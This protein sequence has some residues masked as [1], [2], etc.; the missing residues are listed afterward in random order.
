V[1]LH[2]LGAADFQA[3]ARDKRVERHILGF[4]GRDP[5]TLLGEDTT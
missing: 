3:I 5:V 4:K 1:R 2:R